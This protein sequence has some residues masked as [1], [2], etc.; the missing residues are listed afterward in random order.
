MSDSSGSRRH[1]VVV[2]GGGIT[3]LAAAY[4]LIRSANG[5]PIDVTVL[6]ASSRLGGELLTEE[7]GGIPVEAG[8]DSFVVRKPW[9][10][11]LCKEL[12]LGGEL[13]VPAASGAFV[14]TGGH[15]IPYPRRSAFG[16]PPSVAQ[17]LRW[18]GLSLAGRIRAA[19]EF[20]RPPKKDDTDESIGAMIG[21][22]MGPEASRI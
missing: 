13:V 14:W 1:R 2:V 20:L 8:A 18:R 3:G 6:E 5:R 4:R 7:V 9:A 12:G 16:I 15:L 21:R 11:D 10:V 17:L 22:R 19:T